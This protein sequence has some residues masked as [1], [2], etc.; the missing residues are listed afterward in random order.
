MSFELNVTLFTQLKCPMNVLSYF[1]LYL[2]QSF[3]V[4]SS[5]PERTNLSSELNATLFTHSECPFKV[6]SSSPLYLSQSFIELSLLPKRINLSS[7]LKAT[8]FTQLDCWI[9]ANVLIY[10]FVKSTFSKIVLSKFACE[11]ST[12]YIFAP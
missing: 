10:A 11:R 3:I 2:S 4:L 9:G 8:E 7:E 12:D 6:K 5:L 1:P